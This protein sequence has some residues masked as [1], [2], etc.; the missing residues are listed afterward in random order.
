MSTIPLSITAFSLVMVFGA[1]V[2]VGV[3]VARRSEEVVMKV[4]GY[5]TAVAFG[6]MAAIVPF[7]MYQFYAFYELHTYSNVSGYVNY[8][9]EE[10]DLKPERPLAGCGKTIL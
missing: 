7:V 5:V 1:F 2:L 6:L 9:L 3:F 4:A 10:A 8:Y